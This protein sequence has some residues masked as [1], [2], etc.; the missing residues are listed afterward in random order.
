MARS[1]GLARVGERSSP[2]DLIARFDP[3]R[4]PREPTVWSPE[5]AV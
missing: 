3:D 1:L 2:N 4:L 5:S